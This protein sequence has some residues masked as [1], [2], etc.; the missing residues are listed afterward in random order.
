M[1]NTIAVGVT[2]R[3]RPDIFKEW[4]KLFKPNE[5]LKIQ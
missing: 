1:K 2:T 3:N 4:I 5:Q